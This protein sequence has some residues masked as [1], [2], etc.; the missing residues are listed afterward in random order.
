MSVLSFL[1][2]QQ[3]Y[4]NT[5]GAVDACMLD[6]AILTETKLNH[7]NQQAAWAHELRCNNQFKTF[8]SNVG[9]R[10]RG[11]GARGPRA[12]IAILLKTDFAERATKQNI[13]THLLGYILEIGID[14]PGQKRMK[15]LGV[16]A[17][18]AFED[19]RTAQDVYHYITD[20]A[21]YCQQTDCH[22]LCGGDFNAALMRGDRA[23]VCP[24]DAQW[25]AAF[26][27]AH[28][29]ECAPA[30]HAPPAGYSATVARPHTFLAANNSSSSRVDDWVSDAMLARATLFPLADAHAQHTNT[31]TVPVH[32]FEHLSD[33][34]P[35]K[36]GA[37][38][39]PT[40]K[41]APQHLQN[42]S[43]ATAHATHRRVYSSIQGSRTHI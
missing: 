9:S 10:R 34:K 16:Y 1:Q 37:G 15:L 35:P 43:H 26:Q 13:P 39:T 21:L 18:P 3:R 25:R 31:P 8:F 14:L 17:P 5:T 28:L 29:R 20:R 23:S 22:L 36:N 40:W 38:P 41:R 6:A 27:S 42:A 11:C 19:R 32:T 30:D 12:G 2:L 7:A 4:V 24:R 33:H